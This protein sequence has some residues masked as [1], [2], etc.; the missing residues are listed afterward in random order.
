MTLSRRN[1]YT[2]WAQLTT[3]RSPTLVPASVL[4]NLWS[5]FNNYCEWVFSTYSQIQLKALRW[6][7]F[8]SLKPTCSLADA[9]VGLWHMLVCH[10]PAAWSQRKPLLLAVAKRSLCPEPVHVDLSHL[11]CHVCESVLHQGQFRVQSLKKMRAPVPAHHPPPSWT[12]A[13]Q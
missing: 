8:G 10:W 13:R 2:L 11:K 4:A 7:L 9:K 6:A 5:I 3:A 12:K 1:I